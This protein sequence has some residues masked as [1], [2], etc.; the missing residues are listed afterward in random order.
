MQEVDDPSKWY[1]ELAAKG[2]TQTAMK[3]GLASS[4]ILVGKKEEPR[5][6]S[7]F[8]DEEKKKILKVQATYQEKEGSQPE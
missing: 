6:H 1:K 7:L 8:G 2:D 4:S 5:R 3:R